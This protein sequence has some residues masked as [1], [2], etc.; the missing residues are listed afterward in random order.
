MHC[1]VGTQRRTW[2]RGLKAPYMSINKMCLGWGA[3]E[4]HVFNWC[5]PGKAPHIWLTALLFIHSN[6]N[7]CSIWGIESS[8]LLVQG[9]RE[10]VCYLVLAGDLNWSVWILNF[11]FVWNLQWMKRGSSFPPWAGACL[12][13]QPCKLVPTHKLGPCL[14]AGQAQGMSWWTTMKL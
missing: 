4:V 2:C 3:G 11:P 5:L 14:R 12:V 8:L 1:K 10:A 7:L 6:Q 13:T 9:N